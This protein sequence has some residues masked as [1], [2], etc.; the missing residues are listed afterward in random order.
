MI[1]K[2]KREVVAY[3]GGLNGTTNEKVKRLEYDIKNSLMEDN[4]QR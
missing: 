2:M 1:A 4:V 3:Y